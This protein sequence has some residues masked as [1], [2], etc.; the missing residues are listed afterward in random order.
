MPKRPRIM[1]V[2]DEPAFV[3][4]LRFQLQREGYEVRVA[5][6]GQTAIAA[7][8]RTKPDLILLDLILPG[9]DGLEVCRRIRSEVATPIIMLTARTGLADKVTGLEAGADDY[10]TKPIQMRELLAR[11]R[12]AL[13]RSQLP[14]AAETTMIMTIGDLRVDIGRHSVF[15]NEREVS[16]RAKEFELLTFLA[17]NAGQVVTREQIMRRVWNVDDVE[18]SRTVDVHIRWLREKIE[19]DPSHPL[20]LQTVRN[21]GY[22]LAG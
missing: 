16:L 7:V 18:D 15:V 2:E 1:L 9:M 22:R 5:P 6:D 21:V 13:R 17:R 19:Q 11:I 12:A 8:Q 20:R 14:P 3:E 10:V 4:A